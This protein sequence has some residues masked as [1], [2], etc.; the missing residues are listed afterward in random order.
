MRRFLET[1]SLPVDETGHAIALGDDVE[2][3]HRRIARAVAEF[4]AATIATIHG[5]CEQES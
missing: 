4:D 2:T 5:F 1:G 3:S